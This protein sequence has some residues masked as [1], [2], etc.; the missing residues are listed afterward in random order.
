MTSTNMVT[1]RDIMNNL[2][3]LVQSDTAIPPDVWLQQAVRINMLMLP[4][5]MRLVRLEKDISA[6]ESALI[7]DGMT[8]AHAKKE[9]YNHP[10]YL[11][12]RDQQTLC[13]QIDEFIKL[14]KK[15]AE[16][17]KHFGG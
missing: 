12:W 2:A 17:N 15:F 7:S 4:E 6:Y 1:A 16:I 13:K 10:K 11:E 9:I 5:S 3:E 14:A 8:A